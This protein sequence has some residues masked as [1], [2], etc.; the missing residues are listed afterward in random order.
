MK[1]I[2]VAILVLI[3]FSMNLIAK[4]LPET[5]KA[6]IFFNSK[7]YDNAIEWFEKAIE[8]NPENKDYKKLLKDLD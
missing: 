3:T 8:L 5:E 4:D 1:H 6:K 7:D 2:F